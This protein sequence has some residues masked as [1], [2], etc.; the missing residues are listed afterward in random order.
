MA[1]FLRGSWYGEAVTEGEILHS[2]IYILA[3][4]ANLISLYAFILSPPVA[5]GDSP[6][7]RGGL[8]RGA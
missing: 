8:R 1:P 5:F 6:L 7:I 4:S 2:Q 3:Y